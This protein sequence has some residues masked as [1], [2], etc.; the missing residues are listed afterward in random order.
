MLSIPTPPGLHQVNVLGNSVSKF[1]LCVYKEP[2]K[3]TVLLGSV[4]LR[5]DP[6]EAPVV[7][8][9]LQPGPEG[10]SCFLQRCPALYSGYNT[11][12]V[13]VQYLA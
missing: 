8:R 7:T 1:V 3:T 2:S 5:D 6:V 4:Y 9:A 13:C 10:E 12:A 11:V